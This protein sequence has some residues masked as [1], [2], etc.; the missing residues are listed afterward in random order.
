MEPRRL[1]A[2]A[3]NRLPGLRPRERLLLLERLQSPEE[4]L[5]LRP[6]DLSGAVGRR[7]EAGTVQPGHALA[8]A[9]RDAR[10]LTMGEFQCTFYWEREYPPQL[11]EIYDPPV[12]LYSRGRLPEW[13]RPMV[14]VVGT[15][16]PTGSARRAAFAVGRQLGVW[17]AVTVSGL[18]RGID[19]EAHRGSLDA[20][21][22]TVA[23]LGS[24]ID[25]IFP[26]SSKPLARKML[27]GSGSLLSEYPPGVRAWA[28]HFPARNRIISG[29]SRAVVVVQAPRRSGALITAQFALEQGRELLVHAAGLEGQAGAGTSELHDEGA[30]VV[31]TGADI[32]R[33]VD[34]AA[35]TTAAVGEQ[36]TGLLAAE[37]ELEFGHRVAVHYGTIHDR[38]EH[39]KQH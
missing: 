1:L 13:S 21:G 39:G 19:S 17:G 36:P 2:L 23:V 35:G 11:R 5:R 8:L 7:P 34:E 6:V 32:G 28:H 16:H 29:L 9:E 22:F 3:L 38:G 4:L 27:A 20:Q 14:A 12:A 25:E 18:A 33:L 15:R 24:A 30:A 37:L 31:A 26:D 10:H